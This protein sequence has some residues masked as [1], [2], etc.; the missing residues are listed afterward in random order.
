MKWIQSVVAFIL[1]SAFGMLY[2]PLAHAL[3]DVGGGV[4]CEVFDAC[5]DGYCT[6]QFGNCYAWEGSGGAPAG[7]PPS[8]GGLDGS[9]WS[10][11]GDDI[12]MIPVPLGSGVV[13]KVS[14]NRKH[15]MSDEVDCTSEDVIVGQFANAADLISPMNP[16]KVGSGVTVHMYGGD[17]W[18]FTKVSQHGSVRWKAFG[19][20]R[21]Q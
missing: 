11:V 9:G 12:P 15:V 1:T 10:P 16:V 21:P 18:K 2:S 14:P 13:V 19:E 17:T 6:A 8:S 4:Y 7:G 20:C 5:A 3:Y